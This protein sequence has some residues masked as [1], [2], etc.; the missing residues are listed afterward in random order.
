MATSALASK[1]SQLEAGWVLALQGAL[2]GALV[3][4]GCCAGMEV[5]AS[6]C[7][8]YVTSLLPFVACRFG[9]CVQRTY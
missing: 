2:G 3:R 5:Q 1:K 4:T 9:F 7:D 6:N 8:G